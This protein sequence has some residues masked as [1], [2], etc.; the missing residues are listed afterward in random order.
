MGGKKA[1]DPTTPPIN[2]KSPDEEN[3]VKCVHTPLHLHIR[4]PTH[5]HTSMATY[6]HSFVCESH[7]VKKAAKTTEWDDTGLDR[8]GANTLLQGVRQE[9]R[10]QGPRKAINTTQPNIPFRSKGIGCGR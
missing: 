4:M 9:S 6:R 3:F 2:A 1:E 5:L 8:T 10:R 7:G